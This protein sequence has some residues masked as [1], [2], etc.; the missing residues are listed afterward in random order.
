MY[1]VGIT[2]D[3]V[4][5]F[6]KESYHQPLTDMGIDYHFIDPKAHKFNATIKTLVTGFLTDEELENYPNLEALI[7]PFAAINQLD[8]EALERRNIKIFNT[9]AH[10]KFVAERALALTLAVMG[11][12]VLFHKK[13]E[14]GDWADRIKGN[15]GTGIKWTS[16]FGKNVAI[17]GYGNIGKAL[18]NLLRPFGG[19]IGV[20]N[21]KDREFAGVKTFDSLEDMATWCDVLI[22]TTS[23]NQTTEGRINTS[24]LTRLKDRVLINVGRGAIIEEAALYEALN[25][26]RLKGFGSDVWY[27]YP[28][29]NTP[30]CAPSKY[31]IGAFEH[32]VMTPHNGGTED[33]S[34]RVKYIDVAT[35]LIQISRRDYSRQIK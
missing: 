27:N 26:G 13:L 3:R 19:Q 11:K 7:V 28:D 6:F 4:F 32:V 17:Y 29:E 15:G 25:T 35:Q 33:T 16:L 22:I 10:A 14:R 34:G 2:H 20:L 23:L 1:N 30:N 8:L 21:Y 18:H 24:I 31:P 9:S 5:G 12:I